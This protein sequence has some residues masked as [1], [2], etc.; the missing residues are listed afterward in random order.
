MAD[1]VTA[2]LLGVTFALPVVVFGT[3]HRLGHRLDL[4]IDAQVA[5][6]AVV[7][8]LCLRAGQP[9]WVSGAAGVC[10]ALVVAGASLA[11][12]EWIR[13]REL[14][15]SLLVSILA[16][17]VLQLFVGES[18]TISGVDSRLHL[19]IA[20]S[21]SGFAAYLGVGTREL[22]GA[23]VAAL[24]IM[25]GTAVLVIW[26]RSHA[27]LMYRAIGDNPQLPV[28]WA[29]WKVRLLAT[30]IGGGLLGLSG[31]VQADR[32]AGFYSGFG[33]ST[34]VVAFVASEATRALSA[35]AANAAAARRTPKER[36][37]WTVVRIPLIAQLLACA[38][39][40][41]G[42]GYLLLRFTAPGVPEIAQVLILIAFLGTM[43]LRSMRRIAGAA[44]GS[45]GFLIRELS[46]SYR[47]YSQLIPALKSCEASVSADRGFLIVWGG[48]GSGKSTLLAALA[49][50][51]PVDNGEASFRGRPLPGQTRLLNQNPYRSV[52]PSLTVA[53]N[54][55]LALARGPRGRTLV[56]AE[57]RAAATRLVQSLP[58]AEFM[59]AVLDRAVA[60][61]SG[62][63][64]QL[65]A[66]T[67]A[68]ADGSQVLLADE[69]TKQLDR[70][71]VKTVEAMLRQVA[72]ERLVIVTS[73]VPRL[74][75]A[76]PE[77]HILVEHHRLYVGALEPA[78]E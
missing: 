45:S 20:R 12:S 46:K 17:R 6:G 11:A 24:A 23:V 55:M 40:L 64:A 21:A 10:G 73:H 32:E 26:A 62:G 36:F 52:A 3:L 16:F 37:A 8:S 47:N 63:Q 48:N 31:A 50:D 69:P 1:F 60:H 66:I 68:I 43:G 22:T 38:V 76:P 13:V 27:G 41:Y 39:L 7:Y 72:A 19:Q 56:P 34:L 65:V 28:A 77:N 58:G 51:T 14:I 59:S 9:V 25:V 42:L 54:L 30:I 49:G 2:L 35:W 57:L 53:E 18:V 70:S 15:A 4:S 33:M 74:D 61:L 75:L 78:K 29:S 67:C 44:P 71:N 5:A